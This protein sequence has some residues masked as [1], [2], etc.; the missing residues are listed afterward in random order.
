M[1][2]LKAIAAMSL[3]RV[4]GRDGAIPWHIPEDF[5]WFKK[6][7]TGHAILMGRK[8]F[9]SLGKPLPG[10]LNI[11]LSR[12][13]D[14][15][16]GVVTLPSLEGLETLNYVGEIFVIGGGQVYAETL[17][18]CSD[19]YLSVIP[20]EVEGDVLFPAFEEEFEFI[21]IL[22]RHPEFEV[23]HYR[24]ANNAMAETTGKASYTRALP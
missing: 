6:M 20:R 14:A 1:R 9:T 15:W 8:T 5:K 11:V 18:M 22:L 16:Q 12:G 23:R 10:R 21:D 2:P 7:T 24:R 4:I 3:N 19:L 13:T 17:P